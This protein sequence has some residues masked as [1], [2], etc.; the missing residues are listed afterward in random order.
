MSAR[1]RASDALG[2]GYKALFAPQSIENEKRRKE[3]SNDTKERIEK[4]AEAANRLPEGKQ[5]YLLGYA[6]GVL[7]TR[8]QQEEKKAG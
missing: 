2:T 5:E 8:E 7:D 1:K 4:I 6:Q 3:M